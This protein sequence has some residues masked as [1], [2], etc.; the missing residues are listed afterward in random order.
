MTRRRILVSLLG[1]ALAAASVAAFVAAS[2]AGSAHAAKA[3]RNLSANA[4]GK[5][6]F[7]VKTIR[8]PKGKVTLVMRNPR[9][10]GIPH[11]VSVKGKGI[12]KEGRTVDPG[13]TSRVS[14][15]LKKGTYTFYCPVDGHEDGGMK[16]K[17]I[18]S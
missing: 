1:L 15:T 2:A 9:G 10:S 5:L 4:S 7:S 3:T 17:L 18:V 12:D 14:A 8:A 16:G 11:A 6:R 13:G